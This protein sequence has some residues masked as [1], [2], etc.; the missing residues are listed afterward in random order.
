MTKAEELILFNRSIT[1][2]V[3]YSSKFP[4]G[5]SANN[6]SGEFAIALAKATLCFS[7]PDKLLTICFS[8]LDKPTKRN[9]SLM[10]SL[11]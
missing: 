10:R 4:V 6:I 11:N 3:L 7:P 8:F 5:S 2:F 1:T 9:K